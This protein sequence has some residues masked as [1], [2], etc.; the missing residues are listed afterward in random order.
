MNARF[1]TES[2]RLPASN[3]ARKRAEAHI[4]AA[5]QANGG[6]VLRTA[7]RL[8]VGR[9]TLN[10]WIATNASVCRALERARTAD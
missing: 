8:G 7:E 1:L 4:G 6:N 9:A 10:R 3:E 5:L 2:L